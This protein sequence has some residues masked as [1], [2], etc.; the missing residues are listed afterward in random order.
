MKFTR[1]FRR[2]K[3]WKRTRSDQE[4][5]GVRSLEIE[6][7]VE[8]GSLAGA[9]RTEGLASRGEFFGGRSQSSAARYESSPRTVHVG[10]VQYLNSK[11]LIEGLDGE[12]AGWGRLTLDFPSRL[13]DQ[14]ARRQ[15]DVA[16]IP[17]VE[18]F[19]IPGAAVISNACVATRGPVWSVK[20][21]AR[22]PWHAVR[23]LALD[24]GSRTSAALAQ[25]LLKERFGA[26]PTCRPLPLDASPTDVA[27]DAVLVIGDRAMG[28]A[29]SEFLDAWDLGQE[30]VAWTGLPFVFAMW[31]A[32]HTEIDTRLARCLNRSR[33]LGLAA[34]PRIA[35]REAGRL[36]LTT[37]SATSYLKE[38]LHFT[39]GPAERNG[40]RLFQELAAAHGLCVKG[41]SCEFVD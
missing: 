28:P 9:T 34:I 10:A 23:T 8:V 22:T 5:H 16:L 21:Y 27:D 2:S 32:R 11:P 36:G 14:L 20:L 6:S 19:R 17:S 1:T 7:P 40:L 25:I 37:A 38:N 26:N 29:P 30:W 3:A 35:E 41:S 12:L 15:L 13:A 33:D 18:A 39:L 31:V 24:D 4:T